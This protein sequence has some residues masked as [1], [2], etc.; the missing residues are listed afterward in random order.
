MT[1][2]SNQSSNTI[3]TGDFNFSKEI[4]PWLES[5]DGIIPVPASYV[6]D[7]QRLQLLKL[8]DLVESHFLHQTRST[9]SKPTP[10]TL[11]LVSLLEMPSCGD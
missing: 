3:I 7:D 8:L 9:R 1:F 2:L 5:Q 6:S 4:V 11:G 10:N